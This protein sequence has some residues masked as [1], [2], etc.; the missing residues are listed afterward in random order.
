MVYGVFRY[1]YLVYRHQR[2]GSPS[3]VLLTDLPTLVNVV[4]WMVT[5]ILVILLAR[6]GA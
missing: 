4:L 2:G 3:E 6:G 5:V 1:L